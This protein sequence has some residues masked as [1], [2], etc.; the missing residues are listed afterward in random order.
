MRLEKS[1]RERIGVIVL[2]YF[3]K[4]TLASKIMNMQ[5]EGFVSRHQTHGILQLKGERI[6]SLGTGFTTYMAKIIS[7]RN[8]KNLLWSSHPINY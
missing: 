8:A 5:I 7:N 4:P 1:C 3:S 2:H 6:S